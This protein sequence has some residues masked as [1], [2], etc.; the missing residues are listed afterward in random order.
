[1]VLMWSSR[2]TRKIKDCSVWSRKVYKLDYELHEIVD[3]SRG[4]DLEM[5]TRVEELKLLRRKSCK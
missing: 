2:G 5:Q 1:M 4:I 3:G